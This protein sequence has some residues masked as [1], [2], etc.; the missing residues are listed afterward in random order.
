MTTIFIPIEKLDKKI[1]YNIIGIPK[2]GTTSLGKYLSDKGYDVIETELSFYD[3]E[4]AENY[5]YWDR[6]PI[7]ITRNPKETERSYKNSFNSTDD[8]AK[9]NAY[10]K[11]GLQMYDALIYSLEY[12]KTIPDFPHLNKA[13]TPENTALTFPSAI[14]EGVN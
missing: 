5:N 12:L 11:A 1:R 7:I 10:F 14:F 2:C 13:R 6:T 4:R 8:K 9:Q 3:Y